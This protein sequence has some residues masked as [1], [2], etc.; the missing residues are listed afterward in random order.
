MRERTVRRVLRAMLRLYPASF[1]WELGD[2]LLGTVLYRWRDARAKSVLAE[3]RFW[4]TEGV[5]FA[6][7]GFMERVRSASI[8]SVSEVGQAAR[9]VLRARRHYAVAILTL[10]VGIAAVTTIFSVADAVVFR[11]LPY[12]DAERLHLVHTRFGSLELTSNSLPNLVDTRADAPALQQLVGA[13]DRSPVLTDESGNPQRVSILDVTDGY[14]ETL[15]ARAALGRLLSEGDFAADA[16]RTAVI[17]HFVWQERWGSR[18]DVVGA[19]LYLDGTQYT[20]VGVARADFRDPAPVESGGRTAAW[21]PVRA[22][23]GA[24]F[25]RDHFA[26]QWIARVSE[27]S[28]TAVAQDQIARVAGT[29]AEEYAE[30]NRFRGEP[31]ELLLRPLHEA[32]VGDARARLLLLLGAVL[33]LLVLSCVNVANLF[34][35]AG[36]RRRAELAVRAALGASRARLAGQLFVESLVAACMASAAGAA[37]AWYGIRLFVAL[38]PEGTPRLDELVLDGRLLAF[39]V[40]ITMGTAVFFGSIPAWRASAAATGSAGRTTASKSAQRYQTVFLAIEVGLALVLLTGATHLLTTLRSLLQV[41]PGFSAEGVFAL[42]VRPPRS[43]S[44]HELEVR[45]YDALLARLAELPSVERAALIHS[46]PGAR[47]GAWS[48]AT[49]DYA[50]GQDQSARAT[51]PVQSLADPGENF[52][53]IN[54]VLGDAIGMLSMRIVAGRSVNDRHGPGDPLEVVLNETAARRLFP[55]V[56]VPLGRLVAVGAP[57]SPAPMREVVGIAA[58]VRQ[59]GPSLPPDAQIYLPYGQRDVG[60]MMVLVRTR[61]GA[62][63]PLNELKTAVGAVA[64]DVPIDRVESLG[65]RYAATYEEHR[66][67]TTLLSAFAL[68]GLLIAVVGTYA[69]AAQAAAER[70]REFSIRSALGAASAT[71][72]RLAARRACL[73]AAVGLAA[74]LAVSAALTRVLSARI[75]ALAAPDPRAFLA[76]AVLLLACALTA[77]LLPAVRVARVPPGTILRGE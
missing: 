26:F 52:F 18:A 8:L 12:P 16:E 22:G 29:L 20:I 43:A 25:N 66:F 19:S 21:I 10:S 34:L 28:T 36:L 59:R 53:R 51:A 67:L 3:A 63:I 57:D 60:R 75:P 65:H 4:L 49:P 6:L 70:V 50:R 41:A 45:F 44:S 55:D 38:I 17:S 48:Q 61:S 23:R 27:Q 40:V 54:P 14:L 2:D 72:V 46:P 74:G 24:Y 7:D 56:D 13:A 64:P 11:P 31:M 76:A 30:V 5:R 15:G 9:Q 42:D 69:I 33:L 58:D 39:V 37:L 32:T 62:G 68:L 73:S 35:S 47:G 77:A 71:L 1:R